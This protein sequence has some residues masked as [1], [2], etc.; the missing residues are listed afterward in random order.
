MSPAEA[1]SNTRR[2]I[3]VQVPAQEVSRETETLIR[4]TQSPPAAKPEPQKDVHT[5]AA[6]DKLRL[7]LGT[8]VR[9]IRRGKGG[10]VEVDFANEDELQRIYEYLTER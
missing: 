4:K 9:I 1:V 7:A 3:E 5:R 8:R 10:K 6:E 2:E